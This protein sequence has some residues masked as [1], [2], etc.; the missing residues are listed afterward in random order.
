MLG[1][2]KSFFHHSK[3]GRPSARTAVSLERILAVCD[4]YYAQQGYVVWQQV[5]D[6]VGLSRQA[7]QIRLR[8]AVEK[9]LITEELL[10]KYRS[11]AARR[12]AAAERE[13]KSSLCRRY[14][15]FTPENVQWL[16]D[17][18]ERRGQQ[19]TEIVN[20]LVTRAREADQ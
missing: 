16:Q 19:I 7:I 11:L 5:G 8:S 9:G 14:M 4:T 15:T 20:G 13:R 17:E 2:A 6:T 10:D 18:A 1:F 12:N 3:M